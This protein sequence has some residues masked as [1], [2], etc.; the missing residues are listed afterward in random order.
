M[1]LNL[2]INKKSNIETY[3]N[4]KRLGYLDSTKKATFA[5]IGISPPEAKATLTLSPISDSQQWSSEFS[6][7]LSD[8]IVGA[9]K[10]VNLLRQWLLSKPSEREKKGMFIYGPPGIGKTTMANLVAKECGFQCIELNASDHRSE[11]K[12]KSLIDTQT[13]GMMSYFCK[14]KSSVKR[15]II[16]EEVDGLNGNS[17]RGGLK[18][19]CDLID[20]S[21]IPIICIANQDYEIRSLKS[22]C[23][24]I[25]LSKI[26]QPS[27]QKHLKEICLKKQISVNDE[28]LRQ[29]SI[30]CNG[31]M[32]FAIN[33]LQFWSISSDEDVGYTGGKESGTE[34]VT[35]FDM[36]NRIFFVNSN[37]PLD[38]DKLLTYHFVDSFMV[39]LFV[40]ENYIQIS[41]KATPPVDAKGDPSLMI[42]DKISAASESISTGDFLDHHVSKYGYY[43]LMPYVGICST[44]TPSFYVK[45]KGA[46]FRD[47]KF[48]SWLGK[49]SAITKRRTIHRNL[50]RFFPIPVEDQ[51][52]LVREAISTSLRSQP[53]KQK[54]KEK[55]EMISKWLTSKELWEDIQ[56]VTSISDQKRELPKDIKGTLTRALNQCF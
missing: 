46:G 50:R 14:Q 27:I 35:L 29:I 37:Q 19:I 38:V 1:K 3:E 22:R 36:V 10:E 55:S 7:I 45:G 54:V 33:A 40:Q 41:K 26:R 42:L 44:V 51:P 53:T 15:C 9:K 13:H 18:T 17:D 49:Q 6:P 47:M 16:M 23:I 5:K 11:S 43:H 39:P 48:P 28:T 12:L 32:R 8:F 52:F 25:S 34:Q 20:R 30:S 21:S 56:T 31:D 4:Y 24:E 2:I